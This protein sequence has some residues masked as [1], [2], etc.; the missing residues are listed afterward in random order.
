[1]SSG[2]NPDQGT[3][4]IVPVTCKGMIGRLTITAC[5][6]VTFTPSGVIEENHTPLVE[7]PSPAAARSAALSWALN[8]PRSIPRS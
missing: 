2:A 4:F 8:F 1:M 3:S 5:D 7:L 6:G